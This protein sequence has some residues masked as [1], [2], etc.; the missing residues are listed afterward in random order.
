VLVYLIQLIPTIMS[1]FKELSREQQYAFTK[2]KRGENIFVTGAGGTGKTKL[3][4]HIV[5]YMDDM[6]IKYQVCAMTGCAAVLLAE[7]GSRT[8]HS[9]SGL[10]IPKGPREQ[11]VDRTTRSKY[12]RKSWNA[13]DVLVVDEVSMM[14]EKFFE[15]LNEVGKICRR[16]SSPFGG[17]QLVFLGDFYQLPPI[18]DADD[19]SSGRFCFQSEKW[20]SVFPKNNHIELKTY[21]RQSD[22]KY[23]E[24]LEQV[25]RGKIDAEN[26]EYLKQYVAREYNPE[27]NG[28]IVP[29]ELFP[30]RS[31]V[32]F[33]NSSR[34]NELS[35]NKVIY[36]YK[37]TQN[38]M[39][40][41]DSA[42]GK[43]LPIPVE[44]IS[45][46]RELSE[47]AVEMEVDTLLANINGAKETELKIGTVVMCTANLSVERGI[48]N[49]SQGIVMDF[50]TVPGMTE[51]M[52]VVKFTNGVVLTITPFARQSDD[53]PCIVVRQ[54]P[55][56]LAWA[57][58]IHKIQGSTLAMAKMDIGSRIFAFGQ[59]YV[60]LSRIKNLDGLY[61]TEFQPNKIKA[62]PVVDEF[63]GG[64]QG[65][66]AERMDEF[67][68]THR[69]TL[70]PRVILNVGVSASR[71]VSIT[72]V[73]K[74]PIV[75]KKLGATTTT[76]PFS[77]YELGKDEYV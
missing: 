19:P 51:K 29:M 63:Y 55:L 36:T 34:F 31:R 11:I 24:I 16:K 21:F 68:E 57:M 23:I 75:V 30:V 33:I 43:T 39:H 65:W 54:I 7:F 28:G 72:G 4:E 32:D 37:W 25:R 69:E 38:E 10:R 71:G 42:G 40:Y 2:F 41:L 77:N 67:I 35:G 49:G 59:T 60:A 52:P 70:H 53:Y 3:I 18:P 22:P 1:S 9:W 6:K 45:A 48:C 8:I 26:A 74:K 66:D 50:T 13:I 64:F 73:S 27:E 58:T 12:T 46:C 20:I 14:S 44:L 61:L 47:K 17:L 56:C 62:N 5:R 15:L 76:N